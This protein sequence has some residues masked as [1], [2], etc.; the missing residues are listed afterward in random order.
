MCASILIASIRYAV[1]V[2]RELVA[3]AQLLLADRETIQVNP[4]YPVW[5]DTRE[6]ENQAQLIVGGLVE[7]SGILELYEGDLLAEFYDDWI[8]PE[9]EHYR[10]QYLD[11]LLQ[12]GQHLR[13]Q[14]EYAR[15]IE[16]GRRVMETQVSFLIL[17]TLM[18]GT[19]ESESKPA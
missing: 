7:P 5:V 8:L 2:E 12:I 9:R 11:V 6:F 10:Q 4:A 14:S 13:G 3:L 17:E 1:T 19:P 16:F 15:A 18:E